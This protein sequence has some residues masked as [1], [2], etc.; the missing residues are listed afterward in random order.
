MVVKEAEEKFGFLLTAFKYG[1]PPHGGIALGLDRIVMLLTGAQSL[2]DVIAF[3]KNQKAQSTMDNSPDVVDK[4]QLD[5]LHIALKK[6]P[7]A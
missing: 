7:G 6:K 1:A 4:K 5:E 2:R 3:P